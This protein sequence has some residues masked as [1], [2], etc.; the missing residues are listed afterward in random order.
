LLLRASRPLRACAEAPRCEA[1]SA[2]WCRRSYHL[3]WHSTLRCHVRSAVV[4]VL[5]PPRR[6]C[7]SITRQRRCHP[8]AGAHR[9]LGTAASPRSVPDRLGTSGAAGCCSWSATTSDRFR[10]SGAG[11]RLRRRAAVNS[12]AATAASPS[13]AATAL[14]HHEDVR[15]CAGPVPRSSMLPYDMNARDP[16]SASRPASGIAVSLA[17]VPSAP[18]GTMRAGGSTSEA[19]VDAAGRSW[20]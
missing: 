17:G 2:L 4:S 5:R 16:S 8:G 18:R 14:G 3:V 12:V 15:G 6:T 1:A 19:A 7:G 11:C 20:A 13:T 9:Y 10:G